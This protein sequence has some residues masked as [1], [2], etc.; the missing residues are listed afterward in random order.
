MWLLL[1]LQ[2]QLTGLSVLLICHQPLHKSILG[3]QQLVESNW[4]WRQ[5]GRFLMESGVLRQLIEHVHDSTGSHHLKTRFKKN[6]FMM[7]NRGRL[8]S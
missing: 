3:G 8:R 6:I 1:L 4:R 5:W 2:Q 7:T